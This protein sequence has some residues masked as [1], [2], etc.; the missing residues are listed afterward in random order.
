M[1]LSKEGTEKSIEV[2]GESAFSTGYIAPTMEIINKKKYHFG[3]LTGSTTDKYSW[4]EYEKKS[5][6]VELSNG[7]EA[8]V[9]GLGKLEDE[10]QKLDGGFFLYRDSRTDKAYVIT[11]EG[12]IK[13]I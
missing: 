9:V 11:K 13:K 12:K 2:K 1:S 7:K 10:S 8:K 3:G 6:I 5:K 4:V